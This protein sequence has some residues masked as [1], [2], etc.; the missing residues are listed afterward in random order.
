MKH[1]IRFAAIL[2]TTANPAPFDFESTE[3]HDST[4]CNNIPVTYPIN[5]RHERRKQKAMKRKK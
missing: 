1:D 4:K 3:Y 2:A 5:N